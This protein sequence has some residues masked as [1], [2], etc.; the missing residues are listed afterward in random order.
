MFNR[1]QVALFSLLLFAAAGSAQVI[2][3]T[4]ILGQVT[5]GTGAVV[6]GA[7]VAIKNVN[8]GESRSAITSASGLYTIPSV[9]PGTYDVTVSHAGFRTATVSRRALRR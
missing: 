3:S 2:T 9:V 4:S 5:D 7:Q 6:A 1:L 8:T